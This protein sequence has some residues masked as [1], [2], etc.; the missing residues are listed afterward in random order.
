MDQLRRENEIK[1]DILG[2]LARSQHALSL[3]LESMAEAADSTAQDA[4]AIVK[5]LRIIARHQQILT[6][7]LTGV[8]IDRWHS[9]TPA[10]QWLNKE[11]R[12]LQS[13]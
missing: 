10:R 6:E 13:K 2:S 11:L 4:D 5:Y 9:G 1:L 7:K 3:I 8:K 12:L